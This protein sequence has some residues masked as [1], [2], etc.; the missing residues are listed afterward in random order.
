MEVIGQAGKPLKWEQR[1]AS[2][3]VAIK[4]IG[5]RGRESAE[6]FN[7]LRFTFAEPGGLATCQ[8]ID[9]WAGPLAEWEG[10]T[11]KRNG[12]IQAEVADFRPSSSAPGLTLKIESDTPAP[13]GEAPTL[14]LMMM[15]A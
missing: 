4:L 6:W 3:I 12:R 9:A 11:L 8:R 2:G 1:I 13:G 14:R 5:Q 10:A 7:A 15:L